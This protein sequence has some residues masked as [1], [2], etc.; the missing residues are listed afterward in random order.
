VAST[1]RALYVDTSALLYALLETGT[2]PG[3]ERKIADSERL[4]TSRLTLVESARAL[5]RA[6]GMGDVP[7]SRIAD[8]ERTLDSLFD[9][10]EIWELD[11]EVCDLA[12]RVSPRRTLRTLDA[13]HLATF[14][15]ARRQ[16]EGLELLTA[17]RRLQEAAEV[18]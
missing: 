15:L 2:R 13:L 3:L 1:S 10:C 4:L 7:E 9:R 14:L 12:S 11:E 17:D 6:R 16:V 8:A 18:S 5:L